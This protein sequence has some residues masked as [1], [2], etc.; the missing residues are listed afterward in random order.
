LFLPT[1]TAPGRSE[2]STGFTPMKGHR[3]R[4]A[5][6]EALVNDFGFIDE[7]AEARFVLKLQFEAPT[8]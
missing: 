3:L 4:W 6:I 5:Q 8:P 2:P 1:G 7:P